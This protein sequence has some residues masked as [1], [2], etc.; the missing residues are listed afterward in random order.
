MYLGS[1]VETEKPSALRPAHH[2][3]TRALLSA[4]PQPHH[5]G[6]RE[7]ILLKGE[8]PSP[9]RRHPAA[10]SPPSCPY[11]TD[12]CRQSRPA[13]R[14]LTDGREVACHHSAGLKCRECLKK[15]RPLR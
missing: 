3:Y 12:L 11:A 4:I 10:S 6:K 2:P 7:R 14:P 8:I 9:L 13:C 15:I 1:I 5:R